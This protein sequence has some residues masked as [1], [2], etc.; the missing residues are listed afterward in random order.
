MTRYMLI[1]AIA[2]ILVLGTMPFFKRLAIRWRFLDQPSDRKI[3]PRPVPLLGGAAIYLGFLLALLLVERFFIS[4]LLSILAGATL[5]SFLGLWDDRR[6]L[7]PS[8]KLL[9][10]V[11]ITGI[12]VLSGI[13]VHFLHSPFLD[14]I[15]TL[16]WVL[17]ISNAMNLLDNMDGLSGGVAM[18]ASLFFFLLAVMNGQYLVASVTAALLGACVGFLFY[19]LNPASVF[20]GDSGSLF[21]G[22]M[23]AMIGIKLRFPHNTDRITWM[24]P[25]AVL[26]LPIF[27][28]ALV[29]ISR[30][31]RG[32]NPLTTPGKD[33]VSHRLVA[34][35]A[36]RREAVLILYLVCCGLGTLGMFIMYANMLEAYLTGGVLVS[37]ALYSLWRLER[38]DLSTPQNI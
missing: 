13:R 11:L 5:I 26:G 21:I 30:I 2:L 22:F 17:T 27:D 20:M 23:L 36:T 19:N 1:F 31:R 18:V 32:L 28:T 15:A 7:R 8:V 9:G 33:H 29:V 16:L 34:M 10:Q 3:H 14:L 35:G 4:Q 38:V 6:G 24:I 25:I 37:F 12:T